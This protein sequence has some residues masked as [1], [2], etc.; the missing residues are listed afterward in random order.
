MKRIVLIALAIALLLPLG[1]FATGGGETT[2]AK[3]RIIGSSSPQPKDDSVTKYAQSRNPA[4][5]D[6]IEWGTQ[7]QLGDQ[8][9][10]ALAQQ[11]QSSGDLP[12]M[13]ALGNLH[14]D[15]RFMDYQMK[16]KMFKEITPAFLKQYLPTYTKRVTDLG[17]P[18]ETILQETKYSGDGKNYY[19]TTNMSPTIFPGLLKTKLGQTLGAQQHVYAVYLRDDILK[20]IS[21]SSKTEADMKALYLKQNASLSVND[22]ISDLPIKDVASLTSYMKAVKALNLKVGDKPVIPGAI[23]SSSESPGSVRWSIFTMSGMTHRWPLVFQL[24]PDN[25]YWYYASDGF[26]E[27]LRAYNE[28]YN[29]GLLDPEIFVMK[30]DQYQAKAT[31]GQYAVMNH[32]LP[33]ANARDVALQQNRGYGWRYCPIFYPL[34]MT[35][36]NNWFNY[37]SIPSYDI[38]ISTKIKDADLTGIMKWLD[39][40]FSDEADSIQYWGLP[41][42]YTGTGADRR[43]KA[44]YNDLKMWTVYGIAGAKDG[45]YYG[46]AAPINIVSSKAVNNQ[47]KIRLGA[48]VGGF[49]YQFSPTFVYPHVASEM[50][51]ITDIG[52]IS[53]NLITQDYKAKQRMFVSIGW[54]EASWAQKFDNWNSE[55]G[56]AP[57]N[58]WVVKI[59]TESSASFEKN[60]KDYIDMQVSKGVKDAEAAVAADFK[61]LWTDVISKTEIK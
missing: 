58:P 18:V 27:Y 38:F 29:D 33:V 45:D 10:V 1:A 16:Q 32:W 47:V 39:W 34:D 7:S 37:D 14:S 12:D 21:P 57:W 56:A 41:D 9:W 40:Q 11:R 61:K 24:P 55:M 48:V 53:E 6:F 60:W 54:Q 4:S 26:K 3:I 28:W 36:M 17:L 25:S 5:V 8:G 31:N 35:K 2:L 20:M 42:W 43:Y 51:N 23:N 19:L 59:I 44:E 46:L 50:G 22:L 52:A 49:A 30:D 15:G 13:W